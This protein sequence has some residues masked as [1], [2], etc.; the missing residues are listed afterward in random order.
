MTE[1]KAEVEEIKVEVEEI[2]V[3]TE[4]IKFNTEE[5]FAAITGMPSQVRDLDPECLLTR[6]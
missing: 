6:R 5:I 2:K 3:D 4:G 1:I